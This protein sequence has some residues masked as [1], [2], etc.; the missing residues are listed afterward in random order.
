MIGI[1]PTSLSKRPTFVLDFRPDLKLSAANGP[2][3]I[4]KENVKRNR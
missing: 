3:Y 1:L 2:N 4:E